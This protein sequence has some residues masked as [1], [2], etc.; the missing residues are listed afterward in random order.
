[1]I[2][3]DFQLERWLPTHHAEINLAGALNHPLKLADVVGRLN[4]EMEMVYGNT[5]GSAEL[6]RLISRLFAGVN[7]EMVLA[8]TG[9]AEAN[10]I[11]MNH[12]IREGDEF[13]LFLPAYL[14][15]VGVVKAIGAEVKY[16]YLREDK[17]YKPDLDDLAGIISNR[18]KA[19][20]ITNPNNPTGSKFSR[21]ELEAVCNIADKVGAYVIADEALR[22]LE[23]DGNPITSPV[24]IYE[25]GVATGS[26]SKLGLSGIRI[27]WIVGNNRVI[28]KCWGFKDYTT[29]S[30]S[31]LSEFL[32][33]EALKEENVKKFQLRAQAIIKDHLKII[34]AWIEKHRPHISWVKPVAGNTAFPKYEL[35]IDSVSFCKDLLEKESVLL[36]PGDYFGSPKHFRIRYGCKK[37]TLIHGLDRFDNYLKRVGQW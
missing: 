3:E 24:E 36:S 12:L 1:M 33:M 2:L 8:T 34:E 4:L 37:E 25:R 31:G 6:R 15:N 20:H 11:L 26:L 22:G 35:D 27:G 21:K 23:I 19:I 7:E 30:H 5:Q 14:Q 18:T 29:L 17:Q 32:A 13:I 10:F 9:T 28:E 16:C